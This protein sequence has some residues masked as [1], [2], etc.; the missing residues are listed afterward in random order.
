MA[1]HT[2]E[3]E[4]V[5]EETKLPTNL[6][7]QKEIRGKEIWYTLNQPIFL[8]YDK[9]LITKVEKGA[10]LSVPYFAK[11][12]QAFIQDTLPDIFPKD[13][14]NTMKLD[15]YNVYRVDINPEYHEPH[16]YS[17]NMDF[18]KTETPNIPTLPQ[19]Y[20]DM[21][22]NTSVF[23]TS[24]IFHP[25]SNDPITNGFFPRTKDGKTIEPVA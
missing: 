10:K 21:N 25:A 1:N 5:V 8:P 20:K 9:D 16:Q 7:I 2:A 19:Q 18:V 4:V 11:V 24:K 17:F 14:Y 12:L 6:E 22:I 3:I 13:F 23:L 15:D